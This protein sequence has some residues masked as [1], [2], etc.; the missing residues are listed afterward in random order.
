M[1]RVISFTTDGWDDYL[2]WQV[3]D[4]QVLKKLT[5]FLKIAGEI[6][7]RELVNQRLYEMNYLEFGQEEYPKI[8]D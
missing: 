5:S 1:S 6:H 8:T 7:F 3:Y 2:Y 4:K